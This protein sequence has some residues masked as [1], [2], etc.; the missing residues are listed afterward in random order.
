MITLQPP[1]WREAY[2]CVFGGH[3]VPRAKLL[4]FL[5]GHPVCA[6]HAREI[7]AAADGLF[8]A[9]VETR[10]TDAVKRNHKR[11][12]EEE[13]AEA[14]ARLR[15]KR[16]PGLVYY[17]RIEEM[18]K[19]GYTTNLRERMRAYPPNAQ[20]LAAHPG[21][22]ETE[23]QMHEQFRAFL[24]RGREWFSPSP[25]LLKHIESVEEMFGDASALAYEFREGRKM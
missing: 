22:L 2:P 4:G 5:D 18:I 14:E 10:I 15:G 1:E 24:D 6:E 7:V 8:G 16:K 12:K 17:I 25:V 20:L 21:T 13:R 9:D 11:Q 19:I 23:A 3:D